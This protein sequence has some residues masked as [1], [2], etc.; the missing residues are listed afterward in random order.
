MSKTYVLLEIEHR[1]PI[2]DLTDFVAGRAYTLDGV[3][4]VEARILAG[5]EWLLPVRD[6]PQVADK[7]KLTFKAFVR[8]VKG[9]R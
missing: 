7:R 4:G 1:K 9:E 2:P 3:E 8:W 6:V 5:G